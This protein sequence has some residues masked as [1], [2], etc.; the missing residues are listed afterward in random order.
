MMQ[1]E[2]QSQTELPTDL[3]ESGLLP[4]QEALHHQ[5]LLTLQQVLPHLGSDESKIISALIILALKLEGVVGKDLSKED[6]TLIEILKGCV[7]GDPEK[8]EAA[9]SIAKHLTKHHPKTS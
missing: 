1:H 9:L 3:T 5:F 8:K 4:K 6:S 7:E 2:H